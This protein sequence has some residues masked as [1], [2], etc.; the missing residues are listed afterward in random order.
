MKQCK[1]ICLLI[2]ISL[3]FSNI[4]PIPEIYSS[5]EPVTV[6]VT[7]NLINKES[8]YIIKFPL[9]QSIETGGWIK[10][11]FPYDTTLPVITPRTDRGDSG[12]EY[13]VDV[14]QNFVRNISVGM[15]PVMCSKNSGLP[16]INYKEH[17]IKIYLNNPLYSNNYTYIFFS[18][19][20]GIK[21]PSKPGEYT[22]K[23]S[24]SAEPG[25]KESLPYSIAESELSGPNGYPEVEVEPTEFGAVASY[26]IRFKLESQIGLTKDLDLITII[27]PSGIELPP[28]T[29][30]SFSSFSLSKSDIKLNGKVANYDVS[31]NSNLI[32]TTPVNVEGGSDVLIE[33]PQSFGIRNTILPGEKNLIIQVSRKK[34]YLETPFIKTEAFLI[35]NGDAPLNISPQTVSKE[36][37]YLFTTF[38]EDNDIIGPENP[39]YLLIPE[40]IKKISRS[41][42]I[43]FRFMQYSREKSI[44]ATYKINNNVI[45]VYPKESISFNSS[46]KSTLKVIV[47]YLVNPESPQKIKLGYKIGEGQ[48]WK[49]TREV[50][51]EERKFKINTIG[52]NSQEAGSLTGY[53]INFTLGPEK[54]LSP[55]DSIFIRFPEG[56]YIPQKISPLKIELSSTEFKGILHPELINAIGSKLEIK[57]N[58]EI[59]PD[60]SININISL[61][62]GFKNPIESDKYY[63]IFLSTSKEEEV[64]SEEFYIFPKR[65]IYEI[66]PVIKEG[67]IGKEGW[68]IS[69][70][71]LTFE[72]QDPDARI[73]F[74]LNTYI[75]YTE[76]IY[77]NGG[78]Y[79][80]KISFFSQ[81]D[82]PT[83]E[84][85]NVLEVWVDTVKPQ[86]KI[87][88]P[89]KSKVTTMSDNYKIEG[90]IVLPKTI[91]YGLELSLI[92][93]VLM[94]N[95]K[96]IEFSGKDGSFNYNLKLNRGKNQVK[97]L[98]ED[99]AGNTD[100]KNLEIWLGYSITLKINSNK[101][102]V[103]EDEVSVDPP[104]ISNGRTYVPLRFF[105]IIGAK[106]T[107][108]IDQK[109]GAVKTITFELGQ[110]KIIL[111]VGSNRAIV[112]G[113]EVKLD[114]P[115]LIVKGRTYIPLRFVAENLGASVTYIK[116]EQKILIS[117]Y[118]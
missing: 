81:S 80:S 83:R 11:I 72:T 59:K 44:Y 116:E 54:G 2:M 92:D 27:F 1:I 22:L 95:N 89:E 75:P 117:Y 110:T 67:K 40:S 15:P 35:G 108:T 29:I 101:A 118:G 25:I 85:Y 111:T 45:T 70:P 47:Q 52:F 65:V 96:G 93:Q 23:I 37:Q 115:P 103:N 4:I 31:S 86:I 17:S 64:S 60:N 78:Q 94:I 3:L 76:P 13:E 88:K 6:I 91:H 19:Y 107:F 24:T 57:L 62:A 58:R 63:R 104:F 49:Y 114:S 105:E 38:L 8:E 12:E 21:N 98:A 77:F 10:V 33:I 46:F 32:I 53:S 28:K 87:K 66:K 36:A 48:N 5:N 51:I 34:F 50:Q 100:E 71:V 26:K 39:M 109:T 56:T 99:I 73:F 112:N 106:I 42:S 16:E 30:S 84:D 61:E 90:S 74:S 18:N 82:L 79:K 14:W 68:Y 113:K 55:D 9:K 7:T 102:I 41:F 69:P 20:S 97:I 43:Y